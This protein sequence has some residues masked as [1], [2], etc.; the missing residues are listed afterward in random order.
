MSRNRTREK[1]WKSTYETYIRLPTPVITDRDERDEM[2]R[3]RLV[4][5]ITDKTVSQHMQIKKDLT[6]ARAIEIARTHES[7]KKQ[8][9]VD[10]T[11]GNDT[12]MA[13]IDAVTRGRY[14]APDMTRE[15]TNQT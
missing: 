1:P 2:I 10:G 5:G 8:N 14:K 12:S 11:T 13:G 7:V 9:G 4:I 15:C 6:L 3:D